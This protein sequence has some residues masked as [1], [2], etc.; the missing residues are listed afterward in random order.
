MEVWTPLLEVAPTSFQHGQEFGSDLAA[1]GLGATT[2]NGM[3]GIFCDGEDFNWYLA[4]VYDHANFDGYMVFYSLGRIPDQLYTL[5]HSSQ[6]VLPY[7]GRRNGPG[8]NDTTI[9]ALTETVR[10]S[11]DLNAIET[12]AKEVQELL[13]TPTATNADMFALVYMTLYSRSY[14]NVFAEHVE[15]VVRSPGYGSD[16]GWTFF[17]MNWEE[18]FVREEDGK[19]VMIYINGEHPGSFNPL[20]ATTVY[21]WNIIGQTQDGLTAVNPYSHGDIGWLAEDWTITETVAGMDI[22]FVLNDTVEWQDGKS[23]TANDIEFCLEFLR[24][25]EVPR[26]AGTWETLIDVA[27]T[28]ATH[29]T[30][31]SNEAGIGLF[32]DYS[33]LA[34]LIPEHIYDRFDPPDPTS[35]QAVLDYDPNVAYNVAPGYTPGPHPPPTNLFGTGPWVFQFY[36]TVNFYDDMWRNEHYFKSTAEIHNLKVAMFH[37][38]GDTNEDGVVDVLDQQDISFAYGYFV[39]EPNYDPDQDI[40]QAPFIIDIKDLAMHGFY[41]GWQREYP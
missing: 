16:N 13:Y 21:E 28:D 15:G 40:V 1:I 20:Y 14:F 29:L 3:R 5:L 19:T 32:Y 22:D 27:V 23:F 38:V 24:D 9:D 25:Y 11:L 7:P 18:G 30:I 33:G 10:F 26:Y 35:M 2:A 39:G 17:N 6:D 4:Q 8:V 34:P 41:L 36:D 37:E 12:A 31:H